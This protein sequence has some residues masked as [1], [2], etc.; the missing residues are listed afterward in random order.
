MYSELFRAAVKALDGGAD[1][2]AILHGSTALHHAAGMFLF[3]PQTNKCI[4]KR[5]IS[6][7]ELTPCFST[8]F[9]F[10]VTQ[11]LGCLVL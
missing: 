8:S 7:V 11:T 9:A 4:L 5:N 10:F 3:S 1:V 2:N 6:F